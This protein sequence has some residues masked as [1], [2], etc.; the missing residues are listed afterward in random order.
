MANGD[1]VSPHIDLTSPAA[2]ATLQMQPPHFGIITD[3]SSSPVLDVLWD[4]FR[5]STITA[6]ALAD[7]GLDVIENPDAASVAKFQGKTVIPISPLGPTSLDPSGGVSRE[8]A[9]IVLAIYRR[10][11]IADAPGSGDIYLL[12]KSGDL[13]FEDLAVRFVV[14]TNR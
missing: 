3:A 2:P 1:I 8:Y 6:V 4:T 12:M 11:P 14:L 5:E 13:F 9:G 10:T 7:T